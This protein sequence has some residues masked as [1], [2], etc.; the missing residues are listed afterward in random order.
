MKD[1][2][3]RE[4]ILDLYRNPKNKG[5]I[6][7][8]DFEAESVNPL[9]GDKVKIQLKISSKN[10]IIEKALFSGSGCVISQVSASLLCT[11]IIG[12]KLSDIKKINSDD[13]IKLIGTKP[14]PSRLGCA[15]L[16]LK[17]LKEVV[18]NAV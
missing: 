10:K 2:L 17:A 3:Y 8:A 14:S 7:D 15:V 6:K 11:Y 1:T 12:K 16:S 9:C 18:K 4:I 5:E 13:I